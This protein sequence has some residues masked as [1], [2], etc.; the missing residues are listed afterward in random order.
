MTADNKWRESKKKII[1]PIRV[2]SSKFRGKFLSL[3]KEKPPDTDMLF[4]QPLYQK[5]PNFP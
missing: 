3:L 2:L 4:S 5:S 1:L